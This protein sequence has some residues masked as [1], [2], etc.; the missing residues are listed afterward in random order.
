MVKCESLSG[1]L[2]NRIISLHRKGHGYKRISKSMLL[3]LDTVA[4][5]I[6]KFKK[7][8][9]VLVVVKKC[10][11]IGK[12]VRTPHRSGMHGCRARRKP[13]LKPEH[14]KACLAFAKA[15]I[16]KGGDFWNLYSGLMRP[17]SILFD[18]MASKMYGV[19]RRTITFLNGDN[20]FMVWQQHALGLFFFSWNWGLNQG[21]GNDEQFQ[22]KVCTKP[23]GVCSKA[24]EEQ[25]FY[26]ADRLLHKKIFCF[27]FIFHPENISVC[28]Q[29]ELDRL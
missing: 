18:L 9:N 2:R 11:R 23:L 20:M 10:K 24:V 22:I 7:D 13:L 19:T 12:Q 14:R 27:Y 4:K 29:I 21:G 26:F 25:E 3:S 15:H 6:Q 5:V 17:K 8:G 28:F 16:D 1:D